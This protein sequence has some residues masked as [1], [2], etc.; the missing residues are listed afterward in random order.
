MSEVYRLLPDYIRNADT[1]DTLAD[2]LDGVRAALATPL[3]Y[4][5][6]TDPNTAPDGVSTP[7]DPATVQGSWLPW[8]ARLLGAEIDGLTPADARWY[9]AQTGFSDVGS[10]RGIKAAVGATLS[11]TR[12]VVITRPTLW[13]M[14][15]LIDNDEVVD[16]DLTEAVAARAKPAGVALTV[17]PGAPATVDDLATTYSTVA[18]IVAQNKT[19][20]QLRFG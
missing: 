9:L 16:I 8:L 5:N 12:T 19:L 3:N 14:D 1:D 4:L 13:E 10:E 6:N 20:D 2:F 7:V 17:T 18:S 15:L 11:G